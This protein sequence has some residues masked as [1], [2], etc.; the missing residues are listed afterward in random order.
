MSNNLTFSIIIPTYNRSHI[1]LN[2]LISVINLSNKNYEV[3]IIDDGSA[4][5]TK[6]V[7]LHFIKLY[8]LTNFFYFFIKNSERGAARNYGTKRASGEWITFLDSDDLFYP[9]HLDLA[10]DF[11][12]KNTNVS[13]FHSAYEFRN[14]K[15]EVIRKV[16]YPKNG[17]LND[18]ILKGNVFSCFGMF[19][20]S[21]IFNELKFE[22]CRELSGSE[23][24]LL[25]LKVSARYKI[26]FQSQVSGCMVQHDER[27][28]LSFNEDKL[29]SRTNLLVNKLSEDKVF[30]ERYG[31]KVINKIYGHMLT[32]S[33]LHLLL[34]INKYKAIKLFFKGLRYSPIELLK[35]RTLAIL[36]HLV[37]K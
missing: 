22:E 13:V 9:N 36:K 37:L 21:T 23:D 8:T 17:N 28:V 1:I 2:T 32:Y 31:E 26:H 16:I 19:L 3:I 35:I 20:K 33:S 6:K 24:W 25:W 5:D 27:S 4:D 34:S 12:F 18:A 29:L 14:Q 7:V 15:N 30:V 10:S 11:I